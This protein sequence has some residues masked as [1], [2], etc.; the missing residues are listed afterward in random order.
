VVVEHFG[1]DRLI[2]GSDWP[3]CTLA[4]SYAE[5]FSVTVDILAEL[6]G[7]DLGSVLGE[8]AVRTYGLDSMLLD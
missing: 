4:A 2:F 6:V 8:C 1:T 3:V 5:V 7:D